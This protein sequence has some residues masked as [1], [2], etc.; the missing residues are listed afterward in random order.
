MAEPPAGPAAAR[1]PVTQGALTR[2]RPQRRRRAWGKVLAASLSAEPWVRARSRGLEPLLS[3]N[4]V[5]CSAAD[6]V[7][8]FRVQGLGRPL[9]A[10]V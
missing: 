3:N 7:E 8:R 4:Q 2:F 10:R 5:H 9:S 6:T 1:E